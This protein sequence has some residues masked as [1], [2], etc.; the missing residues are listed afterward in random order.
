MLYADTASPYH[1]WVFINSNVTQ[2]VSN[3][4]KLYAFNECSAQSR[5][6]RVYIVPFVN[7]NTGMIEGSNDKDG[8]VW[9]DVGAVA[10]QERSTLPTPDDLCY[11]KPIPGDPVIL[12]GIESTNMMTSS[13]SVITRYESLSGANSAFRLGPKLHPSPTCRS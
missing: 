6:G 13:R 8:G 5:T 1:G 7:K 3:N 2:I 9:I 4:E 12:L 10:D 11:D